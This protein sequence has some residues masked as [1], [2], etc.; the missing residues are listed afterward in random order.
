MTADLGAF[1]GVPV[2]VLG[3]SGFVGRWVARVL[4]QHGAVLTLPVRDPAAA[5]PVFAL[6]QIDGA[7]T[8]LDLADDDALAGT[9]ADARPAVVFNLAG[10]GVDPDERDEAPAWRINGRLPGHLAALVADAR[11]PSWSHVALVHT[12]TA[13]EYGAETGDL[14]EEGPVHPTTLYGK[15]KLAGTQGLSERAVELGLRAVTARLFTVYGPGEHDGRLLPTLL[16]ARAHDEDI[17][18]TEGKQ[19]RDFTYAEEVAQALLRL[20][21]SDADPGTIVNCA[22]GALSTVRAFVETAADVLGLARTRLQFGAVETRAGEME[23]APVATRRLVE[24][25]GRGLRLH[26]EAGVR[27]TADFADE[28]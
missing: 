4:C 7:V 21:L 19:Q 12:G 1:R 16:A 14:D 23:H 25:T 11:D 18:L 3:A 26:A 22:T 24:L 10:Y 6:W 13:A 20:A 27:R 28:S 5:A 2:T 17:S 15:S 8:R 9:L